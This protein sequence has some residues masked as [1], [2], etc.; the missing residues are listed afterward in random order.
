MKIALSGRTG[1]GKSTVARYLQDKHHFA[2]ACPGDH[3][4]SAAKLIFGR[5]DRLLLN[6]LDDAV[7]KMDEDVWVKAALRELPPTADN[8]VVDGVRYLSNYEYLK[9]KGYL[10]CVINSNLQDN[11]K[12][13]S[14]R[15]QDLH[16]E[17]PFAHKGE[18]EFET[19]RFDYKITN[20]GSIDE[21]LKSVDRMLLL[22]SSP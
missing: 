11:L 10:F 7:R 21:L 1:S 12:R 8:I 6:Q 9:P 3:C 20:N 16:V 2:W 15:D 4:R 22:F 5:W 14:E 13:L 17:R 19:I 18:Y